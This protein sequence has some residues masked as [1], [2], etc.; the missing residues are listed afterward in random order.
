MTSELAATAAQPSALRTISTLRGT[1]QRRDEF[2]KN[3]LA[4]Q[5]ACRKLSLE[6]EASALALQ[7]GK[8]LLHRRG[9][10]FVLLMDSRQRAI[11]LSVFD[12]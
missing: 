7:C 8:K 12:S 10:H 11:E 1:E 6:A 3:L 2:G 5:Q 9:K 4:H